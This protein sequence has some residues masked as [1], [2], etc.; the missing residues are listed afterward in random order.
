MKKTQIRCTVSP[1]FDKGDLKFTKGPEN[2]YYY[3]PKHIKNNNQ[4]AIMV[5]TAEENEAF[6]TNKEIER[7]QKARMLLH[8]LGCPTIQDL[9]AI[10]RMNTIANCPVTSSVVDLAQKIYGKDIASI[11]EAYKNALKNIIKIYNTAGFKVSTLSCDRECVPLINAIQDEFNITPNY[12]SAQEH[13][14]EAER[15]NRVIKE[16][17]RAVFSYPTIQGNTQDH[18]KIFSN[19]MHQEAKLFSTKRKSFQVLQPQRD[20]TPTKIGLQ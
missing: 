3:K 8:T 5:Q 6:Y 20:P 11:K 9:K 12:P 4:Q 19:G 1:Q 13:V 16:R 10:L 18:D 17:I 2:L 14:P 7:A 15:N